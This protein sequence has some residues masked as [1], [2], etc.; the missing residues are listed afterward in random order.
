MDEPLLSICLITYNH[1]NSIKQA[2]ESVLSQ[3]VA[4][5]WS[6]VIADDYSTDGTR[7][8]L[9][10]YKERYP[11][12]IHL[13]LQEKNVGPAKNWTDLITYPE[14]KYVA[15]FEG[16]DYWIDPLK[17]QKQID[18]LE[19][20][21]DYFLSFHNAVIKHDGTEKPFNKKFKKKTFTTKDLILK[22]WFVPSASIV[23]RNNN[24]TMPDW[25][26]VN[27]DLA[28]LLIHSLNGK[29][30]YIDEFMSVYNLATPSSS[31]KVV[32]SQR[33]IKRLYKLYNKKWRLLNYFD[34]YTNF[35]FA[36]YT[37][38]KRLKI[39]GGFVRQLIK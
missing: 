14:S 23:F 22:P 28:M 37:S 17:L 12:F 31:S 20:N 27:G 21:P 4:F 8:I 36:F 26:N 16:D 1:Q 5:S 11:D 30:H 9:L 34:R 25:K 7:D 6:L 10:E 2:I 19:N 35:K 24:F 32:L 15:Y 29:I 13:I 39:M 3:Q 33:K 38:I 18:F